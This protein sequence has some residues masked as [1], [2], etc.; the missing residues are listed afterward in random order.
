MVNL[1]LVGWGFFLVLLTVWITQYFIENPMDKETKE[2][3]KF[4]LISL[5]ITTTLYSIIVY[6]KNT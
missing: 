4:I 6:F 2:S 5:I 3:F 1:L